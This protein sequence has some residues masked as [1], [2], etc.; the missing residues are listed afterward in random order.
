[1]A[2]S[3]HKMSSA[4]VL[5]LTLSLLLGC[6]PKTS[7]P[8]ERAESLFVHS[9]FDEALQICDDAIASTDKPQELA[10]LLRLRGRCFIEQAH[11]MQRQ[12]D[13]G[14]AEER[15]HQA[16]ATLTEA[17]ETVDSCEP[18]YFRSQAYEMLGEE[19][20]RA[21]ITSPRRKW[22]RS[23]RW[24]T[25]TSRPQNRSICF[26]R[27]EPRMGRRRAPTAHR[28]QT[29]H[30]RARSRS[31]TRTTVLLRR[32]SS[33]PMTN[34]RTRRPARRRS[35]ADRRPTIPATHARL[36]RAGIRSDR[37]SRCLTKEGLPCPENGRWPG[38]RRNLGLR[39][40]RTSL[41]AARHRQ[42]PRRVRRTIHPATCW[43]ITRTP[44][45]NRR[46]PTGPRVKTRSSPANRVN[47]E[48]DRSGRRR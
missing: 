31:R 24:L 9:Q 15:L 20:L 38:S 8:L 22:T 45:A 37:G 28:Q 33:G 11:R 46:M 14:P 5:G 34:R 21:R 44:K 47:D 36:Q 17:I 42:T 43:M 39:V 10:E 3:F 27:A 2:R 18:R 7:T 1:M 32:K 13:N 41:P 6:G 25:S 35:P 40:T 48:S 26:H 19:K 4:C 23:T 16:V 12:G 29:V 30:L